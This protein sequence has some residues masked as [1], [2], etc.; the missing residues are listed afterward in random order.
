MVLAAAARFVPRIVVTAG[1]AGICGVVVLLAM[2]AL[3][4]GPDMS[5]LEAP[6]GPNGIAMPFGLTNAAAQFGC[7]CSWRRLRDICARHWPQWRS[8]CWR[9]MALRWPW[10]CCS[11]GGVASRRP[12]AFACGLPDG[13]TRAG[14]SVD[15]FR[16]DARRPTGWMARR[17][18]VASGPCRRGSREPR[19]RGGRDVFG[20]SGAVRSLRGGTAAVVGCSAPAGGRRHRC[21]RLA[22]RCACGDVARGAVALFAQ[23]VRHGGD[24]ARCGAVRPRG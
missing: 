15:G 7:C 10:D 8:R 24:G 1:S 3:A 14:G 12:A 16:R 5:A 19:Q 22:T 4:V 2:A 11:L 21:H 17:D 23:P 9:G 18:G 20:A 6:I 13:G